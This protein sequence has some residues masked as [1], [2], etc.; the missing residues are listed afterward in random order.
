M[1]AF[2]PDD[3][4]RLLDNLS[5]EYKNL[6]LYSEVKKDIILMLVDSFL[7]NGHQKI[8][9]QFGCGGGYETEQLSKRLKHLTVV[10]G[11]AIFIEEMKVNNQFNNTAFACSLFEEYNF[12]KI[13]IQYDVIFCNYALEHVFDT[14][15][16]LQNIKSLLKPNGT[17]F[18][19]VPNYLA[20]SRQL[21][22]K[23]G[24]IKKLD[25][26]TEND[27]R[28]GHR[29]VYRMSSIIEDITRSGL[30]VNHAKGIILKILADF[31]LNKLLGN[32]TLDRKHIYAMH[33]LA[34]Q[35]DEYAQ[36]ADSIFIMAT[37]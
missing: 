7:E 26:L 27:I 10:D 34:Q 19:V 22:L 29:R 4:R 6:S 2:K 24:L 32:G 31:Q 25:E 15:T 1:I 20:L 11:S 33:A 17:L 37:H 9:L 16:I 21:A 13:K 8:G 30:S 3:E 28:H 18:I 14:Q 36:L 12:E 35:N 23:M 5:V